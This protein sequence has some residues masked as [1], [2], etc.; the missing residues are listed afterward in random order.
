MGKNFGGTARPSVEQSPDN[1]VR[2]ARAPPFGAGVA[3]RVFVA[4]CLELCYSAPKKGSPVSDTVALREIFDDGGRLSRLLPGYELRAEQWEM[5]EA[6]SQGLQQ[7]QHL[8]V[9]AGTGT[10]KTVAYLVPAVL[11]GQRVVISTGTKALQEQLFYKDVPLLRRALGR[12]FPVAYMKGRS[13]YLCW[14]RFENLRSVPLLEHPDDPLRLKQI[15]VWVQETST[16]D[17]AE[18]SGVNESSPLWRQINAGSETCAGGKC[19]D[20]GRCFITA[21][22]RQAA[23]ADIV[24]VNHHLFFAD[25]ALRERGY[26]EVMPEYHAVIF[27]EA[28]MVEEVATHHF[29]FRVSTYRLDELARDTRHA[30]R[31]RTESKQ[32]KDVGKT[33]SEI[34]AATVDFFSRFAGGADRYLLEP[35]H[36]DGQAASEGTALICMLVQLADALLALPFGTEALVACARRADELG[37]E[38]QLILSGGDTTYVRWCEIRGRGVFLHASPIDVSESLASGVFSRVSSVVLTSATLATGGNFEFI[39]KRLGL[40]AARELTLASPFDT[41]TQALLYLPAMRNDP[42]SAAFGPEAA[43]EIARILEKTQGRAFVLFTSIRRLE[44]VHALLCDHGDHE[45]LK[46][47]E[48]S[49]GVLLARFREA[50]HSVLFATRSFWQGID[51]PGE[52]LSCVI[53]DKLPFASPSEPVVAARIEAIRRRGGNPFYEFQLPEAAIA[54]KQGFGRLIRSK[55]DR[56]V[57][58]ILDRR[59]T[60]RSYGRY[61]LQSLP[62]CP[63]TG[64]LERIADVLSGEGAAPAARPGPA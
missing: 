4:A 23:K 44:E 64:D 56:G 12:D 58:S 43:A 2:Q 28:H 29:G 9:E 6:V 52:A 15:A 24:I 41:R 5:S 35:D 40:S 36:L 55:Q 51:V 7:K 33:C 53:I 18:L 50:I 39:K 47:G 63:V 1:D 60:T 59:M 8:L 62:P 20:L 14:N 57:L 10:G 17:V 3:C 34:D 42:T 26:G 22:R 25:L 45:I 46:Q 27:D 54:L 11:S 61:F 31:G 21:M 13:N 30:L 37:R 16:G 38:L 19:P 49:R 32:E 48:A